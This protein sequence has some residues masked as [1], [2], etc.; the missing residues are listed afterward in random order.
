MRRG[1]R[2]F[3]RAGQL[4]SRGRLRFRGPTARGT[5]SVAVTHSIGTLCVRCSPPPSRTLCPGHRVRRRFPLRGGN[6]LRPRG[7][8]NRRISVGENATLCVHTPH[9][10]GHTRN[11]DALQMYFA[12][13]IHRK[14][15]HWNV[16][17]DVF[18]TG[19]VYFW[20]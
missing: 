8:T 15:H 14:L 17:L 12:S 2:T 7:A 6:N 9:S 13:K 18:Y 4:A 16:V 10:S 1:G 3:P 5:G 20:M 11:T 19:S